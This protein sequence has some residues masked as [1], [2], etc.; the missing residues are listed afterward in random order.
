METG[1]L[2]KEIE[3]ETITLKRNW[4]EIQNPGS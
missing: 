4:L 1:N 3:Q 2:G